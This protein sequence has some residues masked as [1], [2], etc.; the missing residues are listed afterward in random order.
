MRQDVIIQKI[1]GHCSNHSRL[2]GTSASF[3]MTGRTVVPIHPVDA[4]TL[5]RERRIRSDRAKYRSCWISTESDPQIKETKIPDH[6]RSVAASYSSAGKLPPWYL[7]AIR[8]FGWPA[9]AEITW[10]A[11]GSESSSGW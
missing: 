10:A 1:G 5:T 4:V 3:K 2:G 6:S 7:S 8:F 9:S 11:C